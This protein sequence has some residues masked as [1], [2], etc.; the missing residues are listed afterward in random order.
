MKWQCD[1]V[2]LVYIVQRLNEWEVTPQGREN[3]VAKLYDNY[4]TTS[5]FGCFTSNKNENLVHLK[6]VHFRDKYRLMATKNIMDFWE[7]NSK[8]DF[9]ILSL[10]T[11]T[12]HVHWT[13]LFWHC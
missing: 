1:R 13:M 12:C 11:A 3:A 2:F 4:A 7:R 5:K 6:D 8:I 10:W 9:Q